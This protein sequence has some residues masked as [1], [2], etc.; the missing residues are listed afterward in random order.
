[1]HCHPGSVPTQLTVSCHLDGLREAML[2]FVRYGDRA[3]LSAPVP[4]CPGWTVRDLV[5]HQR[6][7]HRWAAANLRGERAD[8]D[9]LE[10]AGLTDADPLEWLADGSIDLVTA[11]TQAPPEVRTVVFLNDA[12]GPKEFWARRQ[13]HETT[14]HAVDALAACLGRA[15]RADEV[16]VGADLAADGIDELLCGFLTRT[17]SRLRSEA[18]GLLVVAPDD[19]DEWWEVRISSA[20]AV[21]ARRTGEVAGDADW[22]LT[23]RAVELY[24]RLWNRGP[25]AVD[26]LDWPALARVEW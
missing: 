24:L 4:T 12:P 20:P 1:M 5:A 15:P 26:L 19:R 17:K 10:R 13:C 2:A 9:A 6:M 8:P 23:G 3:G 22:T 7:V 21:A 11:W 25:D 18:P 16:W 14:I